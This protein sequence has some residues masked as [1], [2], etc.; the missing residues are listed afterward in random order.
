MVRPDTT[1]Q[2]AT[3]TMQYT[4]AVQALAGAQKSGTGVPPYTRYLNRPMGRRLAAGAAVR[5]MTPNQVTGW[6]LACSVLAMAVLAL[7]PAHPLLGLG[8]AALMVLGYALDS[9]DGQLARL[10][11]SGG[12]AGEWLDH[13]TDQFRQ[14]VVHAAVLVYLLRSAP[15]LQWWAILVPLAFGSVVSTR[16]FSQILAEQL[17]RARGAS[18][19][20]VPDPGAD[21]RAW[22]QLPSDTGVLCWLFV[23]AG[24]PVVFFA[25]YS[26]LLLANAALAAAS[27]RRRHRELVTR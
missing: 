3:S 6:S 1:Q 10:Q 14:G 18:G 15:E 7:V 26:A 19:A 20:E 16:F 13:V 8:V 9:A 27:I 5:G 22:L 4:Q 17:R 23:L 21:R 24:W 25:A 11:R 12:P 2:G